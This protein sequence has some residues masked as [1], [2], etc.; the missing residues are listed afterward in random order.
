MS[1]AKFTKEEWLSVPG[2][3]FV[4]ALGP[5]GQNKFDCI[6]QGLSSRI[7]A[8]ELVANAQLMRAAPDL[9]KALSEILAHVEN[10]DLERIP[11]TQCTLC[12]T[13]RML[14]HNALAKALGQ[15]VPAEA[16]ASHAQ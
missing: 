5:D 11:P 3:P 9:Y 1:E 13:F 16:E 4:Y 7:T 2:R 6:V 8:E 12:H 15:P 10:M 14:G